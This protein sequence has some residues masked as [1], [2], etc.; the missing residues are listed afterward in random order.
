M[1]ANPAEELR[2]LLEAAQRQAKEQLAGAWQ[3]HV[4]RVEEALHSNWE[5][6]LAQML[7]ERFDALLPAVQAELE[8]RAGVAVE[9]ARQTAS[10]QTSERLNQAARRLAQ[11]ETQEDWTLTLLD[12]ARMG[13]PR[14][15]LL[16]RQ[17]DGL[18]LERAL[19]DAARVELAPGQAPAFEQVV[20]T[21]EPLVAAWTEREISGEF[22]A[23]IGA[24][25][26]G[27]LVY[28]F[29][30]QAGKGTVALLYADGPKA[31]VDV[32][33]LELLAMV[34]GAVWERRA[35]QQTLELVRIEGAGSPAGEAWSRLS[36]AEQERHLRAQRFARVQVAEWQLYRSELVRQGRAEASLY[37]LLKEEIDR[38]RERYR[39]EF[40]T[41]GAPMADYLHVEMVRT[42][43]NDNE[44]LL[45][46]DYP[47]PQA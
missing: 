37:R 40:L 9:A 17:G 19:P 41:N 12:S 2:Q 31:A 13:A 47:G 26:P 20:R 38:A 22:A 10:R 44:A 30:L 18:R 16:T 27:S 5:Q 28:A 4:A 3:L 32:N 8:A 11:A 6:Q 1:A 25:E 42:L 36:T 21:G 35:P 45:G 43:V 34:A 46:A 39:E 15:A 24:P 7:A 33:A 23:A 29:P 14:V